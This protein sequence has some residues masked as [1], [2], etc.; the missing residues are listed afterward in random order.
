MEK[1]LN[2]I[3]SQRRLYG[4]QNTAVKYYKDHYGYVPFYVLSKCLTFGAIKK[5][6]N[7][8]KQS[9]QST[10]CNEILFRNIIK[11]RNIIII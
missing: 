7:V 10:I 3:K 9:D 2:T 4:E 11:L 1:S 6:Y 8:M 5:L